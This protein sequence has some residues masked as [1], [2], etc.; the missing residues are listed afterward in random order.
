L[1]KLKKR[2]VAVDAAP[3]LKGF[4]RECARRNLRPFLYE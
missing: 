4:R 3:P 1:T 2:A